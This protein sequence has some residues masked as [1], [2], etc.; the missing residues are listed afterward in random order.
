M[1]GHVTTITHKNN[2]VLSNIDPGAGETSPKK[3]KIGNL[4]NIFDDDCVRID[5]CLLTLVKLVAFNISLRFL[6]LEIY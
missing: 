5:N 3:V 1:L 6:T 4:P 2:L